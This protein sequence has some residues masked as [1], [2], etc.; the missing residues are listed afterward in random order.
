MSSSV[1]VSHSSS[2]LLL[3]SSSAPLPLHRAAAMNL[4]RLAALPTKLFVMEPLVCLMS[5]VPT[6][7]M[8]V[9]MVVVVLE[10]PLEV[11]GI[12]V[13]V[14]ETPLETAT[15]VEAVLSVPVLAATIEQNDSLIFQATQDLQ[16]DLQQETVLEDPAVDLY[17]SKP[18]LPQTREFASQSHNKA[19][20]PYQSRNAQ[21]LQLNNVALFPSKNVNQY[22]NK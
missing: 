6:A 3:M 22:Q 11:S 1:A 9:D 14:T 2:A 19:A 17:L 4:N 10:M 16:Q 18:A 8:V 13:V 21:Q 5:S 7:E 15:A 12:E 20:D